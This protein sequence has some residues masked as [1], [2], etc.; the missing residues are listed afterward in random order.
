M[1]YD[2]LVLPSAERELARIPRAD[3]RRLLEK[4]AALRD[5]PRAHGVQKLKGLTHAYR[6]RSG[7]YRIL[8]R[9]DDSRKRLLVCIWRRTSERCVSITK[10]ETSFSA[11]RLSV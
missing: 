10:D 2:V 1:S 7:G 11:S 8:Y 6:V 5:D 3:V 9:I 4:I